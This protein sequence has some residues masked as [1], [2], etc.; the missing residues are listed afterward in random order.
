MT[1]DTLDSTILFVNNCYDYNNVGIWYFMIY[2][3][4][5]FQIDF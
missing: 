2:E 4:V 3:I 5:N 1:R